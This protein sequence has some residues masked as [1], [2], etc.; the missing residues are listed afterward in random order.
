MGPASSGPRMSYRIGPSGAKRSLCSFGPAAPC[1][2]RPSYTIRHLTLVGLTPRPS[3]RTGSWSL[4]R[5]LE[6]AV[7]LRPSAPV[8]ERL[9]EPGAPNR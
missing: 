9:A 5:L 7:T 4:G 3:G 2:E 6:T 1:I 8:L